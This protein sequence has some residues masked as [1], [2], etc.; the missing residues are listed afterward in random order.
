[1]EHLLDPSLAIKEFHRTCK[2]GGFVFLQTPNYPVKR[3]YDAWHWLRQSRKTISDDP[4]HVYHFN[5]FKLQRMVG[6]SGLQVVHLSARNLAFD[7]LFPPVKQLRHS[8]VGHW[9]GQKTMLVATKV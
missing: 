3:V 8:W 1:M 6:A 2:P 9:F 5:A 7:R 4:T